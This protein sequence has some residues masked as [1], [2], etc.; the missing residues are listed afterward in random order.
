MF[1]HSYGVCVCVCVCVWCVCVCVCVCVVCVCVCVCVCVGLHVYTFAL[2]PALMICRTLVRSQILFHFMIHS[3][4]TCYNFYTPYSL[5]QNLIAINRLY[6]MMFHVNFVLIFIGLSVYNFV[7]LFNVSPP[8]PIPIPFTHNPPCKM[9]V[10]PR[11]V[12]RPFLSYNYVTIDL[13]KIIFL[14]FLWAIFLLSNIIRINVRHVNFRWNLSILPRHYE[15]IFLVSHTFKLWVYLCTFMSLYEPFLLVF[16][17]DKTILLYFPRQKTL[18]ALNKCLYSKITK[19][20]F[21]NL[22]TP[23]YVDSCFYI[24]VPSPSHVLLHGISNLRYI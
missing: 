6:C 15:T 22:Q 4:N 17:I 19:N 7:A 21:F 11:I 1:V 20:M 14:I 24:N 9:L 23:D 8:S 13:I 12:Q 10:A 18:V 16:A 3:L 2:A 5:T